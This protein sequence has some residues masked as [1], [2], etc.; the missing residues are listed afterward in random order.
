MSLH[1]H[2]RVQMIQRAVCFF[3]TVPTT[4]VHPLNLFIPP[5]R[6]LVLLRARNRYERVDSREWMT[7][8]HSV[9]FKLVEMHR[10]KITHRWR[11]R[12]RVCDHAWWCSA[13]GS[14]RVRIHGLLILS[15]PI[16]SAVCHWLSC[17]LRLH[18]M[19]WR[20][21]G[22]VVRRR[23]CRARLSYRWIYWDISVRVRIVWGM[24]VASLAVR[25]R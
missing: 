11:S 25:C 9:S 3:A 16:W 6:S 23:I 15:C 21:R 4:F 20:I 2:V 18:L 5:P 24:T 12:C 22:V 8:L 14:R 19:L 13:R 10:C 17:V 1:C 7:S